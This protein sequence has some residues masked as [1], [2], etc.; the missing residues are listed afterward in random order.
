MYICRFFHIH[1]SHL[2]CGTGG[3]I[4]KYFLFLEPSSSTEEY[5]SQSG[6]DSAAICRI[7]RWLLPYQS[8]IKEIVEAIC[9]KSSDKFEPNKKTWFIYLD[10]HN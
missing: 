3:F 6:G 9:N 5:H 7:F 10:N 4:N 1:V 8:K 2:T